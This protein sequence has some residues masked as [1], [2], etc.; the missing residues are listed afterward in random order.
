[1]GNKKADKTSVEFRRNNG[2]TALPSDENVHGYKR[3][4]IICE[5]CGVVPDEIRGR[6]VYCGATINE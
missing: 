6:C 2:W 4:V 3:R 5:I 1:M